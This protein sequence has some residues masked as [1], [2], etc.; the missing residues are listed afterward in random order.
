[1][2]TNLKLT[3][4]LVTAITAGLYCLVVS[5]IDPARNAAMELA[6]KGNI[7]AWGHTQ[8]GLGWLIFE[9]GLLVLVCWGDREMGCCAVLGGISRR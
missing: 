4:L 6:C 2:K 1:M 8:I 3:L 5:V 9:L 7:N